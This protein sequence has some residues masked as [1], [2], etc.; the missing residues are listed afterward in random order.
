M[1]TPV[2]CEKLL[3]MASKSPLPTFGH[4]A[5]APSAKV[6]FGSCSKAAG[7]V[8]V[9]VPRPSQSGHQPSELLNE[10][11]CGERGSK[12][13]PHWSQA[14][15][16][17]WTFTGQLGSDTS[18]FG[19]AVCITPRPSDSEFS[20]LSAIRDR[21]SGRIVT[22]STS[23]STSCFRRRSILGRSSVEWVTPSIRIRT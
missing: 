21:A 2:A 10:K 17:L 4:N 14:K 12:L 7:L 3:S 16:W 15:C 6:S 18:S 23:T 11:L 1:G 20:T 19:S 13:R 9:S 8:P 5:T 22:R